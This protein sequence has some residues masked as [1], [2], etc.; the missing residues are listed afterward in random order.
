MNTGV[1]MWLPQEGGSKGWIYGEPLSSWKLWNSRFMGDCCIIINNQSIK[2][3]TSKCLAQTN[4]IYVSWAKDYIWS[5]FSAPPQKKTSVLYFSHIISHGTKQCSGFWKRTRNHLL[6]IL[7]P[8]APGEQQSQWSWNESPLW[9]IINAHWGREPSLLC[10][11][12]IG[13]ALH[14]PMFVFGYDAN[15]PTPDRCAHRE[16]MPE[17]TSLITT[18][19]EGRGGRHSH[20]GPGLQHERPTVQ[21]SFHSHWPCFTFSVVHFLTNPVIDLTTAKLNVLF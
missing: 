5:N 16:W 9:S 12:A 21:R 1:R 17:S 13:W 6:G 10:Q 19:C 7:P 2:Q 15:G 18:N 20:R 4:G 3:K 11:A 8:S 14:Q